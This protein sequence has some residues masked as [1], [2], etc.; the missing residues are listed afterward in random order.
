MSKLLAVTYGFLILFQSLNISFEDLGKLDT[1]FEHAQYHKQNFGDSFSQFWE[2]HY[3]NA[4]IKHHHKD[5]G[6]HEKLPFKHDHQSCHHIS[7][8]FTNIP[9][10]FDVKQVDFS[11]L[12]LNYFY[13]DGYSLFEKPSIFQPPKKA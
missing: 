7:T 10:R 13:Q 8:V 12:P 2:E 11:R 4:S 3:G 5:S 1:L 6:Q 9:F